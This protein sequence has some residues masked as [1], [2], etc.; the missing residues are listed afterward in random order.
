MA[1]DRPRRRRT[2]QTRL[3]GLTGRRGWLIAGAALLGLLVIAPLASVPAA[4]AVESSLTADLQVSQGDLQR[5]L[6]QLET[7]YKNQDAAQVKAASASFTSSRDRL[8]ALAGRI[9]P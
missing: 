3:T 9:R 4:R 8:K 7:G 1:P 5:G 2:G 6:K